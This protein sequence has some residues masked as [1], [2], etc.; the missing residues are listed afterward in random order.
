ML[1]A[2]ALVFSPHG[3]PLIAALHSII[4]YAEHVVIC[5][6][7]IPSIDSEVYA[8]L[9]TMRHFSK[10]SYGM[11]VF[12]WLISHTWCP[13]TTEIEQH[14]IPPVTISSNRKQDAIYAVNAH[15]ALSPYICKR[16]IGIFDLNTLL[17]GKFDN[18]PDQI[19]AL[20]A[21]SNK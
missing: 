16:H 12:E 14:T 2:N 7:L 8:R 15:A 6:A 13:I 4:V 5:V 9:T 1:W 18:F 21:M 20:N 17:R 10:Y 3:N 11:L 19:N